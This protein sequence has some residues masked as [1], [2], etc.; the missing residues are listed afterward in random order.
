MGKIIKFPGKEKIIELKD[1][2]KDQNEY[3][4]TIKGILDEDDYRDVLCAILDDEIY[5]SLDD[6]LKD[7]VHA[8]YDSIK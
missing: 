3:L 1:D 5:K 4:I 2:P 8:Y 6:D 7:V